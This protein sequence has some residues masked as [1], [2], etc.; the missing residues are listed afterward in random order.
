MMVFPLALIL[1]SGIGRFSRNHWFG[2]VSYVGAGRSC[3]VLINLLQGQ[4]MFNYADAQC[5]SQ[6]SYIFLRITE[7]FDSPFSIQTFQESSGASFN[8]YS[9][10]S[11]IK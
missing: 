2:L 7:G 6:I 1:M 3:F 5:F 10:V 9:T 4:E 11:Q 8:K